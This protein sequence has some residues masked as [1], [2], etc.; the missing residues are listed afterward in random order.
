VKSKSILVPLQ[1]A[2]LLL[3]AGFFQLALAQVPCSPDC[4]GF[5][6][7]DANS[8]RFVTVTVHEQTL[9]D[10][11]PGQKVIGVELQ[12]S[13]AIPVGTT[14]QLG[15]FDG[16]VG[17]FWDTV[18]PF[19]PP[20]QPFPTD[21]LDYF[22]FADGG[23]THPEVGTDLLKAANGNV[24][25]TSMAANMDNKWV[26]FNITQNAAAQGAGGNFFYHFVAKWETTNNPNEQNLFKISVQGLPFLPAGSTVG[27]LGTD[28]SVN[29]PGIPIPGTPNYD[30]TFTFVFQV[31]TPAT[32]IRLWDGDA[33]YDMDTDDFN[34]GP[35]LQKL[36]S[37]PVCPDIPFLVSGAAQPE[38]AHP[39][40]P[41]FPN[42]QYSVTG[43]IG[44]VTNL[45]PSG[46]SEI[47]LY[48][49]G[50]TGDATADVTVPA[51]PA[52]VYFWNWKN[53]GVF[54][55]FFIHADFDIFTCE[56]NAAICQP[57]PPGICQTFSPG[58]W[59]NHDWIVPSISVG[60][61]I[62]NQAQGQAL[63]SLPKRGDSTLI[64]FFQVA[65]AKINIGGGTP[66]ACIKA[67]LDAADAFFV[68]HPPNSNFKSNA[69]EALGTILDAYNNDQTDPCKTGTK[70]CPTAQPK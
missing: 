58:Y 51:I 69:A 13:S 45:D 22:L 43:P 32:Q 63:M 19:N 66:S 11:L 40:N 25:L 20:G 33:D 14:F 31:P 23:Q 5:P 64:L 9:G 46:A 36:T 27:L 12:V 10:V 38:G 65:A 48:R 18:T 50:L 28:N 34:T 4:H 21:V 56:G 24:Q 26:L 8:G 17:G 68:L 35:C 30:S 61:V 57:P 7:A 49:I 52:G 1:T 54:N 39:G 60:G 44:T 42:V 53:V 55:N 6:D 59:K 15:L 37:D 47:E 70:I 62:Y 16:D 67:T 29:S 41:P 3:I 2:A